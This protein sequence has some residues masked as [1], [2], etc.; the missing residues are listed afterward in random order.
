MIS[1]AGFN[2]WVN[3]QPSTYGGEVRQ[4]KGILPLSQ[5]ESHVEK[6]EDPDD[7][8]QATTE[9]AREAVKNLNQNS[10][11]S[12]SMPKKSKRPRFGG[13]SS[14]LKKLFCCCCVGDDEDLKPKR[15]SGV[16]EGWENGNDGWG[17]K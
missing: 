2:E 8:D 13:L 15:Q 12:K 17:V 11:S 16:F 14:A 6:K 3:G 5:T 4:K 7:R 1:E 10:Y 9:A